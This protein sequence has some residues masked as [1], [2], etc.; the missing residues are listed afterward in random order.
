MQWQVCP[1]EK[2]IYMCS[3]FMLIP[4]IKILAHTTLLVSQPVV[5]LD[6]WSGPNQYVLS[7]SLKLTVTHLWSF[8]WWKESALPGSKICSYQNCSYVQ[9]RR[10][11]FS[12]TRKHLP[13]K[14]SIKFD[15]LRSPLNTYIK[16]LKYRLVRLIVPNFICGYLPST[17]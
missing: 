11:P 2:Y 3:F 4:H 5:F 6:R 17:C 1:R 14:M 10:K 9:L 12:V 7:I 8:F 13:L 16:Q 15:G